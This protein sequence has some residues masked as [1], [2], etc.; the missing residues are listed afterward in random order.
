MDQFLFLCYVCIGKIN[1]CKIYLFKN[2]HKHA[3]FELLKPQTNNCAKNTTF[4]HENIP[5]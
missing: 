3:R 5:Q 4:I 2:K 1:I